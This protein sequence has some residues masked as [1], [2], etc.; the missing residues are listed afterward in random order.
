[1]TANTSDVKVVILTSAN[2]DDFIHRIDIHAH[3]TVSSEPP[4]ANGNLTGVQ[5]LRTEAYLPTLL[6]IFIAEINGH[7]TGAGNEAAVQCD[8]RYAG[9]GAKLSRLEIGFGELPGTGGF[10]VP[11]QSDWKGALAFEYILS[12]RS[13]HEI[14]AAATRWV[15]RAFGSEKKLEEGVTALAERIATF[16]KQ[17]L[18]AI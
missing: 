11:D 4:P 12:A 2:P 17:G 13:V 16:P 7:T 15:N 5:L 9:P 14:E 8:I 3:S 1:M 6:I 10:A 18:A